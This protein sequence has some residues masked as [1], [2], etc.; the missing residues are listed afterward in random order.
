[1]HAAAKCC[2][3]SPHE[4]EKKESGRGKVGNS[5]LRLSRCAGQVGIYRFMTVLTVVLLLEAG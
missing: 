4:K 3:E 5:K 1:M 2:W